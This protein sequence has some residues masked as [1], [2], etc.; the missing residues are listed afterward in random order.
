[1]SHISVS[2]LLKRTNI[3]LF[4][5]PNVVGY[6]EELRPK[7]VSGK[8]TKD[9]AIR[10]YVKQKKPLQDLR[11]NEVIPTT[12]NSYKTD[13]VEVGEVRALYVPDR[14]ARFITIPGSVSVAEEHITA[15]THT[16]ALKDKTDG[17][18]VTASN[19]HVF[20]FGKVKTPGSRIL[21]PGPYDG[22]KP[23][24]DTY[25]QLKRWVPI[26][27]EKEEWP[28]W[29]KVFCLLFG[30]LFKYYCRH[31]EN[32][33]DFAVGDLTGDRPIEIGVLRDDGSL[34]VP[35]AITR[36]KIGDRVWKIGRTSG[37]T[38]GEITD[39]N[40]TIKVNYGFATFTF[41]EQILTTKMLEP[42]DSG[43]ALFKLGT[44][45]LVGLGFAGSYVISVF[46]HWKNVEEY[47]SV[48]L[49]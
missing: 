11:P 19:W 34:F 28:W 44:N 49:Q 13:V 2:D 35:T 3:N 15:G 24:S 41:H 36:A 33:V 27:S 18:I 37:E 47:G 16:M 17:K 40:A 46:N 48:E 31:P 22:G 12:I 43:S 4:R 20:G 7:I 45:E 21:Q 42:G 39:D 29:K 38:I 26:E 23:E 14:R 5:Y 30:W 8:E 1:M 9:L 6:S 10:I 32:R 25:A